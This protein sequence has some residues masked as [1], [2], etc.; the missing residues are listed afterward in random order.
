MPIWVAIWRL[1]NIMGESTTGEA[2]PSKVVNANA[3]LE[4]RNGIVLREPKPPPSTCP[5]PR[6]GQ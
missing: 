2:M 4:D 5:Q 1:Q 6:F 3:P